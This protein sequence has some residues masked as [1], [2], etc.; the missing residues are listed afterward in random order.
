MH[1]PGA[2]LGSAPIKKLGSGRE[3]RIFPLQLLVP[4]REH[5]PESRRRLVPSAHKRAAEGLRAVIVFSP[6]TMTMQHDSILHQKLSAQVGPPDGSQ[7]S[8]QLRT[9]ESA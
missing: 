1:I 3:S 7:G 6:K 5:R 9:Q 4:P 2:S 8:G